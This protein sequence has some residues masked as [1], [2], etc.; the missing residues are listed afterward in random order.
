MTSEIEVKINETIIKYSPI[1]L[2]EPCDVCGGFNGHQSNC[3]GDNPNRYDPINGTLL[4]ESILEFGWRYGNC[5][6][7]GKWT[8]IAPSATVNEDICMGC[9]LSHRNER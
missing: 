9:Y 1:I 4:P 3:F 2:G 8:A 6:C 5:Y 7:C